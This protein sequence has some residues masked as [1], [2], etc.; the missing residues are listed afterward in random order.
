MVSLHPLKRPTIKECIEQFAE[1]IPD[2]IISKYSDEL[3]ELFR[4]AREQLEIELEEKVN[5][6]QSEADYSFGSESE[7]DFDLSDED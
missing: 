5:T 3:N 6:P 1:F 7:I 2:S 4:I